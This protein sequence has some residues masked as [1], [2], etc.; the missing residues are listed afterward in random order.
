MRH[1]HCTITP[2]SVRALAAVALAGALPWEGYGRLATARKVLD[3]LLLAAA[4]VSSLSAVLTR[5]GFGFG[6]E[7]AR[8]AVDG[9]PPGLPELAE[10]L[11]GA[12]YLLGSRGLRLRGWVV[13]I[14]EHR[15]PFYGER[16]T[17]GATGGQKKHG[18]KYAFGYATAVIVHLRHRLTVGLVAL[19]GGEKPHQGRR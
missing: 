5:F 13:A 17:P 11:L 4:L 9:N 6:R 3:A 7:T 15:D 18:T 12:L 10:G 1:D 2:A 14:D 19:T 16:S 8:K